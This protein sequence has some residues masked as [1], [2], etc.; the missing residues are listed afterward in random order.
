MQCV[1]EGITYVGGAMGVLEVMKV[2][3][4]S[5]R[6]VVPIRAGSS[7]ETT[8]PTDTTTTTPTTGT[9]PPPA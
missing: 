8:W 4:R 7:L 5:A 1:A 6:R 3:A 2:R 9:A